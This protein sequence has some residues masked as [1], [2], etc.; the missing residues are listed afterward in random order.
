MKFIAFLLIIVIGIAQIAFPE[1]SYLF[2]RRWM[3]KNE[4]EISELHKILIR[5]TGVVSILVAVW[6]IFA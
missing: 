4:P 6:M 5:V 1:K 3:Y 2:G